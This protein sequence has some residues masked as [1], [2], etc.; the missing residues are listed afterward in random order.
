[1]QLLTSY[2]LL[3]FLAV[4]GEKGY[5]QHTIVDDTLRLKRGIYKS[6]EEFKYNRPSR[7]LSY[8]LLLVI[9]KCGKD[10]KEEQISYRLVDEART[11]SKSENVWGFCDGRYVF[12]LKQNRALVNGTVLLPLDSVNLNQVVFTKLRFIDRYCYFETPEKVISYNRETKDTAH[13]CI[14]QRVKLDINSG[15]LFIC[16]AEETADSVKRY[17]QQQRSEIAKYEKIKEEM[18][19]YIKKE[20]PEL[21]LKTAKNNGTS[22]N[23]LQALIRELLTGL[24]NLRSYNA[25]DYVYGRTCLYFENCG[26]ASDYVSVAQKLL[27]IKQTDSWLSQ[28]QFIN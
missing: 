15:K 19:R 2:L 6:F 3:L 21:G 22:E 14:V 10:L 8:P 11:F 25:V 23:D 27:E 1:M 12:V 5:S 28:Q 7:G 9:E 26:T 16:K 20:V 24:A 17:A 18:S 4:L 13:L